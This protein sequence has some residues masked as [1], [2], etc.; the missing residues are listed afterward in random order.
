MY[1]NLHAR[2]CANSNPSIYF[3][4]NL[5]GKDA[6]DAPLQIIDGIWE[7]NEPTEE[8]GMKLKDMGGHE[9]TDGGGIDPHGIATAVATGS[10]DVFVVDVVENIMSWKCHFDGFPDQ[11][12]RLADVWQLYAEN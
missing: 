5:S 1:S 8:K 3:A 11:L 12:V 9:I 6:F 10:N 4:S 2:Y 7:T